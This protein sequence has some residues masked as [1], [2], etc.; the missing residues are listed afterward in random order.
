MLN[1]AVVLIGPRALTEHH[2][3]TAHWGSRGIAPLIL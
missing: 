3:I 2:A 1:L